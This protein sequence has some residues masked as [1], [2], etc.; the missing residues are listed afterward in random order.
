M[1]GSSAIRGAILVVGEAVHELFVLKVG[2]TVCQIQGLH[3]AKGGLGVQVDMFSDLQDQTMP[4]Y[5]PHTDNA[6]AN[7]FLSS[8]LNVPR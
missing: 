8:F 3:D 2:T 1:V 5:E 7:V 6:Y 4:E